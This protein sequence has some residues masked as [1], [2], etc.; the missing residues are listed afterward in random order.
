MGKEKAI[1]VQNAVLADWIKSYIL[2]FIWIKT[3]SFVVNLTCCTAVL[4]VF[5]LLIRSETHLLQT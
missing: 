5:V 4:V 1:N 3:S 2:Y